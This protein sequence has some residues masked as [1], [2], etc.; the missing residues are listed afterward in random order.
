MSQATIL[1]NAVGTLLQVC[2]GAATQDG[3]GF[4]RYDAG[5]ARSLNGKPSW[6]PAQVY[7]AWKMLNK[8]RVQL[9]G[10]GI[11]I[12]RMEAPEKP[13]E[14]KDESSVSSRKADLSASRG[15]FYVD[16]YFDYDTELIMAVKQLPNAKWMPNKA[17]WRVR[18]TPASTFFLPEF[19][20]HYEFAVTTP[21]AEMLD[22]CTR[23][24]EERRELSANDGH[25][26]EPLECESKY[27]LVLRPFQRAGIIYAKRAKKCFFADDMGLGKTIQSILTVTEL[28]AFPVICVVPAC[29]K[30]KWAREWLKWIGGTAYICEGRKPQPIPAMLNPIVVINYDILGDWLEELKKLQ[31]KAV[32]A[33]ESHMVKNQKTKRWAPLRDLV[34][35][36][37]IR[38]LL[39]GTPIENKTSE[40]FP[41]FKILGRHQ[42]VGDFWYFVHRYCAAKKMH[43]G[44]DF[45]G[46]A[47][48]P[49]LNEVMRSSFYIRRLKED[50]AKDLPSK[51]RATEWVH[52]DNRKEYNRARDH[53]L[54]WIQDKGLSREFLEEL[55]DLDP[56]ERY[57]AILGAKAAS[58]EKADRAKLLMQIGALKK[59]IAMGKYNSAV[60]WITNF[61]ESGEKLIVFVWHRE[62]AERLAMKFRAPMIYGGLTAEK[63]QAAAD[64]FMLEPD[65]NLIVCNMKAAGVG[66]DLYAAS[67]VLFL[68]LGWTPTLHDQCEDRAHRIGQ[69]Q[70]VTAWYMLA[71]DSLDAQFWDL[72]EGKRRVV[73][74]ATEGVG[75]GSST[76]ILRALATDLIN[77]ARNRKRKSP[78]QSAGDR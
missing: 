22:V 43:F 11:D 66:L 50:V 13:V 41:Q 78:A 6:S 33:D 61:L 46:S 34:K 30:V 16:L 63:R 40:F 19:I 9:A 14:K 1:Q 35:G 20:H 3:A 56:D 57:E 67:N 4:N 36:V 52:L 49:E 69:T 17:M 76:S 12:G 24:M 74:E 42:H 18:V 44:W 10:L 28:E 48:L 68:E 70:P 8:Y 38:L 7:A 27:P 26:L 2:D 54:D 73:Q 60:E 71:E 53:F 39:T 64:S 31:P 15:S 59:L 47:N 32:I 75:G 77:E 65:T 72:L 23:E 55:K 45:T 37:D 58:L 21:V 29:V 25:H 5:F 62:L 51:T